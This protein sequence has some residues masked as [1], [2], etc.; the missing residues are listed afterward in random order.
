M[1]L[2]EVSRRLLAALVAVYP[3]HVRA[4]V[5]DPPPGLEAAIEEG[6]R[7]LESEL[8][9]LLEE[10]FAD[11][12]RGPLEVFQEGMRFPTECL[13]SAGRAPAP[14]DPATEVALPG[15]IYDLAP[16]STRELGEEV[17]EVHIA[18]G[19]TKA[20]SITGSPPSESED[21]GP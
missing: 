6:R 2:P 19:V 5:E 11:Q 1:T 3:D 17:W 8:V 21:G 12:R 15:D 14:R 10:P 18:W 16:A 20:R 7:W 13:R 4:R 9:A